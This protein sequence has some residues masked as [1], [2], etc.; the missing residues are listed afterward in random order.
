MGGHRRLES[1]EILE[2]RKGLSA[3]AVFET[4]KLNFRS[5]QSQTLCPNVRGTEIC[6]AGPRKAARIW[7]PARA[8]TGGSLVVIRRISDART[9]Q[10]KKAEELVDKSAP[11]H[12]SAAR[13]VHALI[14]QP[15]NP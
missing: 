15:L 9:P 5:L 3:S 14:V 6:Y 4:D 1:L 10:N 7:A 8:R 2:Y 13:H 11:K 12:Q